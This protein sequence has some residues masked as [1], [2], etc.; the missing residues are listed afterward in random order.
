[1]LATLLASAPAS[2]MPPQMN[3]GVDYRI[4]NPPSGVQNKYGFRG[5]FFEVNSPNITS[6]YSQVI[7]PAGGM[8]K[9]PLPRDVVAEFDDK[10][11]WVTGWEVDVLR[12]TPKGPVSVPC[13]ESYNHHCSRLMMIELGT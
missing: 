4:A 13:Y 2:S 3:A 8:P 1:M 12:D 6:R 11:M 7:W 10:V 9:V 5:R